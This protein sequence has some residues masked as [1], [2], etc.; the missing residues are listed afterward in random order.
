VAPHVEHVPSPPPPLAPAH[1][2]LANVHGSP[3]PTH[4]L[5]LGSQQSG[6]A[7]AVVGS[8]QQ[9]SPGAPHA[10]QAPAEQIVLAPP[11]HALPV[12]TH[13]VESQQPLGHVLPAQQ[14]S[15]VVPHAWHE[16]VKQTLSVPEQAA[17]LVTQRSVVESQ[18]PPAVVHGVTPVQQEWPGV[19]HAHEPLMHS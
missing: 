18:Q 16:P 14:S 8:E 7:H 19:P 6:A 10:L 5:S 4:T 17:P 11:E 13:L 15:P 12:A 1:T 9:G 2:V 3:V